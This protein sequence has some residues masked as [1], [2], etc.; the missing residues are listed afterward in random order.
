MS[1]Q[2]VQIG[3][4]AMRQDGEYWVAYY[5][6]QKTMELAEELGRI[7][8]ALIENRPA[9]KEAFMELMKAA[10]SDFVEDEVGVRPAWNGSKPAPDHE[11][12]VRP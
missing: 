2:G 5:A 1:Q 7:K 3:R 11:R 10:F 12:G 8:I 4:L 6:H 9:R